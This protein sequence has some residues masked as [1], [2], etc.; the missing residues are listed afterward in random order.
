MMTKNFDVLGLHHVTAMTSDAERNYKFFT[1]ILGMRLVKKT[2]NQDDIYTYHTYFADDVGSSGTVMTFFDFPNNPKGIQGNNSIT[3]TS[4]RVPNDEALSY[5][6][7]RF[8][9]FG[10]SHE[11]IKAEFG[12]KV[13]K[14]TD[15]DDQRYQLISDEKNVGIKSGIP[16]KRGPVPEE[17]AIIGLG[18]VEITVN[19]PEQ[20]EVWLKDVLG[21]KETATE[22]NAA[23][24][25][26][27]E[28]GNGA[29]VIMVSDKETPVARQGFGEVHHVAVMVKDMD[30]INHWIK[31][32]DAL[33]LPNSGHVERYYFDSL[34][35]RIG[36]ILFEFAT[37]G[38]GFM[39][40]EPYET[41][42]E[43]LSLAPFLES[44]RA[45]IEAAIR[46]FDTKWEG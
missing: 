19:Y 5:Y 42:G 46:P 25:E 15:F 33:E 37:D 6:A 23:L 45:E 34:Y 22:N 35:V 7:D 9:E 1:E 20:M 18:P 39:G 26:V 44:K 43:I 12:K 3:R 41:M 27:G 11:E 29:S 21:F 8:D 17:F 31:L 28:G 24:Y 32:M 10:V 38:P 16:W 40:D 2:V 13:L 14:F 4:F 36:Y 30:A